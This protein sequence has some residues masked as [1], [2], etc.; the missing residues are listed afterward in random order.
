LWRVFCVDE[1]QINVPQ[2]N[3]VLAEVASEAAMVRSQG[4]P[5]MLPVTFARRFGPHPHLLAIPFRDFAE[6][7]IFFEGECLQAKG[8]QHV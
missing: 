6:T 1:C 7:K 5:D 8:S 3:W 4:R 2:H